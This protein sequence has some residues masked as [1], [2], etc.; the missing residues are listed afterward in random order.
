MAELA[1]AQDS[2]S[3][4]R[5]RV[6]VRLLSPAPL[7]DK[8]LGQ[9]VLSPCLVSWRRLGNILV[10]RVGMH[11]IYVADCSCTTAARLPSDGG[12]SDGI[13]REDPKRPVQHSLSIQRQRFKRSLK[14]ADRSVATARNGGGWSRR[15]DLSKVVRLSSPRE[16][17]HR[18]QNDH[19]AARSQNRTSSAKSHR[20]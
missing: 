9:F 13:T 3:C 11:C 10:T 12:P 6:E 2:G 14:T 19:L 1:D 7:I 16:C 8:D 18:Y 20:Y 15:F 4:P 17:G 5:K